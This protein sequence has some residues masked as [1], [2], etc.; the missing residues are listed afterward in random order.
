MLMMAELAISSVFWLVDSLLYSVL[1]LALMSASI[2]GSVQIL[3]TG[4][5]CGRL[6]FSGYNDDL[7]AVWLVRCSSHVS[8]KLPVF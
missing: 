4:C 2:S 7:Y 3:Q 8:G 6:P 5:I 1:H